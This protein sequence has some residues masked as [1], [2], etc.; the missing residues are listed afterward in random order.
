MSVVHFAILALAGPI[1]AYTMV[2]L[3]EIFV[4]QVSAGPI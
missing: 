2:W 4:N 3:M 1:Q